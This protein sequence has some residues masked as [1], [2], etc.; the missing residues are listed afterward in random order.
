MGYNF[1]I[2]ASSRGA[3]ACAARAALREEEVFCLKNKFLCVL[4]GSAVNKKRRKNAG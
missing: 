4:C 1:K 2:L 3:S